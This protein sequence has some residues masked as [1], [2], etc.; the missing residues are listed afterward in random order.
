MEIKL[1]ELRQAQGLSVAQMCARLG[2][3]DSRYRKWESNSAQIPLAYA[4]SC[5]DILHCS[6]DELAG[7]SVPTMANDERELLALYRSTDRRGKAS[8]MLVARGE[9]GVEGES[10]ADIASA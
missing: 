3:Q 5:C 7:R 10:E 6:L 8:I 2:I 4:V 1:K 9:L